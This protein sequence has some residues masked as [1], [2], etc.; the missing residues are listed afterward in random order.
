M[1]DLKVLPKRRI[2]A[3][4][5]SFGNFD[6]ICGL[7]W[8]LGDAV[9][10][11]PLLSHK[12]AYEIGLKARREAA[13]ID[14]QEAVWKKDASRAKCKLLDA[15]DRD[16]IDKQL[17]GRMATLLQELVDVGLRGGTPAAP[18]PSGSR[19]RARPV[20][21]AEPTE[22]ELIASAEEAVLAAEKVV[23]RATT[24]VERTEAK[25]GGASF[26]KYNESVHEY[27]MAE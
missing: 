5:K 4:S 3:L 20:E 10:G 6:R 23:K 2:D 16:E 12:A 22:E 13:K 7:G 17:H 19:K 14:K 21:A 15:S 27:Y 24:R 25:V 9:L 26:Y 1:H 18:G 8:L 11:P